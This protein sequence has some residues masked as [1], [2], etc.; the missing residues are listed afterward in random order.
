MIHEDPTIVTELKHFLEH[1]KE[2]AVTAMNLS[3]VHKMDNFVAGVSVCGES[4]ERIAAKMLTVATLGF[5][6]QQA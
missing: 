6:V 5:H 3:Q 4:V 2:T 1:T